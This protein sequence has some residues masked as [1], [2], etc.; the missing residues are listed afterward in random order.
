M[1]IGK[2]AA[3]VQGYP[4]TTQD[5]DI[6]PEKSIENG[7]KLLAAMKELGFEPTGEQEQ[8]IVGGKDFIQ[9]LEPFEFDIVFSPDGFER[10]HDAL[11]YKR[12]I[13]GIPVMAMEGIIRSKKAANRQKDRESLPRMISF[14]EWMKQND[15]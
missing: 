4:D 3:M 12:I 6:Y 13:G 10:Y 1:F 2:G 15:K 11:K 5:A 7:E 9:F 8:Q 14:A